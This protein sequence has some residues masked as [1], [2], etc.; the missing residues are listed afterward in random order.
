MKLS[1]HCRCVGYKLQ[2]L[3]ERC[4]EGQRQLIGQRCARHDR[5]VKAA[6]RRRGTKPKKRGGGY[7]ESVAAEVAADAAPPAVRVTAST[8]RAAAAKA[9][10]EAATQKRREKAA[11]AAAK[12]QEAAAAAAKKQSA[13]QLARATKLAARSKLYPSASWEA[14]FWAAVAQLHP[15]VRWTNKSREEVYSTV[16]PLWRA[17]R[18]APE[19]AAQ[20]VC[21]RCEVASDPPQAAPV[22][23]RGRTLEH[24]IFLTAETRKKLPRQSVIRPARRSD[25]P[26]DLPPA[27]PRVMVAQRLAGACPPDRTE[28]SFSVK[29]GACSVS[30]RLAIGARTGLGVEQVPAR[31][32][33]MEISQLH[34]S[35]LPLRGF[36]PDPDY[37]DKAQ[38]RDYQLKAE[39]AKVMEIAKDYDPA[40]IFNTSPGA[41]DGVP[42]ACDC[43]FVLGGNGR[44]MATRLVYA[45]QGG[46]PSETPRQ[47]LIEHAYEFGFDAQTVEQFAQPML[48]RTIKVSDPKEF[49]S[50]SRRLNMALSQQLDGTRLAVS[51]ANYLEE[52]VLRELAASMGDD[53]TLTQYLSSPRSRRFVLALQSSGIIDARSAPTYLAEG[54]LL[55]DA[56]RDL[57][58]DLLVAVLLP[59]ATLIQSY[60]R[61]PVATLA[62]GAPYLVMASASGPAWDL[63]QPLR[64]AV[65]DR[66]AMRASGVPTVENHLA[67]VGLFAAEGAAAV[68]GDD[69]AILLLRVLTALE[70]APAKFARFA[71]QYSELAAGSPIGQG[72]LFA[73]EK[74]EPLEALQLA[75]GQAGVSLR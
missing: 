40:L 25:L 56:G 2:R 1:N 64:K 36:A 59:D 58:G 32:C 30:A 57:V 53:E 28:C 6:A 72:A 69:R 71:R 49:A 3:L 41:I 34:T 24:P 17:H 65:R 73:A 75:A 67:Q 63:R 66:V 42:V 44:T 8:T 12:K 45:G 39:R 35:H 10:R 14:R 50:W 47:Y 31:Y 51:R 4:K 60:G 26:D 48:V 21:L 5:G 13:A 11:A 7:E 16:V 27:S 23:S 61:G 68:T 62:R 70:N 15:D 52:D 9:K 55:T 19:E 20:A 74:I 37:P 46:V 33:I 54:G 22:A 29:G 38:E 43:G 18:W